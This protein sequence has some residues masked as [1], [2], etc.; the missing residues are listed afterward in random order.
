VNYVYELQCE[1]SMQGKGLGKHMMQLMELVARK[2]G[3]QWIMVSGGAPARS[4]ESVQPMSAHSLSIRLPVPALPAR[5][6]AP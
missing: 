6:P 5:P 4:N 1:A 2:L 3:L